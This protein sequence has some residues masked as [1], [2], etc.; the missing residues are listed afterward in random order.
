MREWRKTHP[1][2]ELQ[3]EKMNTRSYTHVYVKRE[4]I[5]KQPCLTC[6]EPKSEA[7]HPNYDEPLLVVWLCRPHHLELHKQLKKINE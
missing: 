1:L 4:K 6:K 5:K 7:H 2:N 3:R